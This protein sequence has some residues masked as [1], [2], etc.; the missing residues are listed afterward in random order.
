VYGFAL[1]CY[2]AAGRPTPV[3]TAD[4]NGPT[5]VLRSAISTGFDEVSYASVLNQ[6]FSS[7]ILSNDE[8]I[9]KLIAYTNAY[10]GEGGSHIQYNIVDT[11]QL[12]D[13]QSNPENYPD[14]IVRIGGFSAYFTQLST[15]IQ[16]DVIYR[17]EFDI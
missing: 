13:A 11:G 7:S 15:S 2:L 4:K 14:L 6:K 8:N 10:M 5:A 12:K 3:R 17:S 16:N 1:R 9:N